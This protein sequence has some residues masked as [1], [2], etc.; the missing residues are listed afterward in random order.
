MLEF[1]EFWGRDEADPYTFLHYEDLPDLRTLP[2]G[3][4][5]FCAL[6]QLTPAGRGIARELEAQ[7]R[8]I[9]PGLRVLNSVDR[10][11]GRFELLD[12]LQHRALNRHGAAP[13][14]TDLTGLR[15][16][17]FLRQEH[18]HLGPISPLLPDPRALEVGLA[19]AV[20]RG[21]ALNDLLVVEYCETADQRGVYRKYSAFGIGSAIVPQFVSYGR[22]WMLRLGNTEFDAAMIREEWSWVTENPHEA[23]LRRL[24]D[25][26]GVEYGRADYAIKDGRIETWE[27]N[28]NPTIARYPALSPEHENL[29]RPTIEHFH[30]RFHEAFKTLD[31]GDSGQVVNLRYS[32]EALRSRGAMVRTPHQRRFPAGLVRAARPVRPLVDWAIR[33]LS[34]VLLRMAGRR[35]PE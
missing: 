8:R 16:P 29:R 10:T 21:Y 3:T 11:L 28:L 6:D 35:R 9:G 26:A 20:V 1:L 22:D 4:Y 7:L 24:F 15:Y 34:P 23:E 12:T 17:V 14:T 13:A 27:I 5:V 31:D 18:E 33:S 25:V 19:G 32:P 30:R 2:G